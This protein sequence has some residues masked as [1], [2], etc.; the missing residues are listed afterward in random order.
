M[1]RRPRPASRKPPQHAISVTNGR[2]G[3]ATA[4]AKT[5]RKPDSQVKLP[6]AD[7]DSAA[8]GSNSGSEDFFEDDSDSD[9]SG[10][11]AEEEAEEDDPYADAEPDAAR[12]AQWVDEEEL[13][14]VSDES[15]SEGDEEADGARLVRPHISS[16]AT[17]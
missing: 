4:Q 11:E 15:E 14:N 7:S 8:S 6:Q 16:F 5:P 12:V 9:P 10:S 2:T 3:S 17:V 1:P 13:D